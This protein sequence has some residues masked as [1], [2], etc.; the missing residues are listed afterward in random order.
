MNLSYTL[1]GRML[2]CPFEKAALVLDTI[3]YKRICT[4]AKLD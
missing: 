1:Y 4:H 2:T 3:F